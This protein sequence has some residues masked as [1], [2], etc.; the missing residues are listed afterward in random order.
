MTLQEFSDLD[1]RVFARVSARAA[2]PAPLSRLEE[3]GD[4]IRVEGARVRALEFKAKEAFLARSGLSGQALEAEE[5]RLMRLREGASLLR[6]TPA[7]ATPL[8]AKKA[9]K[10]AAEAER[11]AIALEKEVWAPPRL[12]L[13]WYRGV[14][15]SYLCAPRDAELI[16][17]LQTAMAAAPA[18]PPNAF[19]KVFSSQ[20]QDMLVAVY[21]ANLT[22]AQLALAEK[23]QAVAI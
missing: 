5:M 22:R 15:V 11:R 18:L 2:Q 8:G 16:G 7:T 6:R 12:C 21:L 23:L 19:G 1:Q 13:F 3:L 10:R 17:L 9:G 4:E 20:V 14:P